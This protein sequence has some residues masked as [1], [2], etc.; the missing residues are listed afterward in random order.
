[1]SL[2]SYLRVPSL[3]VELCHR[4]TAHQTLKQET[5]LEGRSLLKVDPGLL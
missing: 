5:V 2:V 4:H 1:M 3:K